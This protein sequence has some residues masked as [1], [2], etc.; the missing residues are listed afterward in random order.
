MPTN[1]QQQWTGRRSEHCSLSSSSQVNKDENNTIMELQISVKKF[2]AETF[3]YDS[4]L[5]DTA[6]IKYLI[7]D[8]D[9]GVL[10]SLK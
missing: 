8:E 9:S 7:N 1:Q 2:K 5:N 10:K 3:K 4:F 6:Q